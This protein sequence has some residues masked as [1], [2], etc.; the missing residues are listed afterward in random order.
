MKSYSGHQSKE[1]ISNHSSSKG[2]SEEVLQAVR[3]ARAGIEVEENFRVIEAWISPRLL[4]YFRRHSFS[5]EDAEDLVQM[6]LV[7]VY[8]GIAQLK[9]EERVIPWLFKIVRNVCLTAAGQKQRERRIFD[10]N[11]ETAKELPDPK[12]ASWSFDRQLEEKRLKRLW[13]AIEDLPPQQRQCLLLHI[14]DGM[15][16]KEIAET[17]R[18]SPNTVRNHLA[19]ATKRLRRVLKEEAEGAAGL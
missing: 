16:R 11:Q 18:L 15:S 3:Q 1:P 10:G 7:R 2:I 5:H 9:D 19:E 4:S 13:A 17:L 8:K 14:R 12:P 6:T